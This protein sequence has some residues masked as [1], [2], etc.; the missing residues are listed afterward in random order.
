MPRSSEPPIPSISKGIRFPLE[1][2]KSIRAFA[3]TTHRSYT[4]AVI[5]LCEV[6]LSRLAA[7]TTQLSGTATEAHEQ[8]I[9]APRPTGRAPRPIREQK[10]VAK[11]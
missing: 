8:R 1:L 5:E 6:A 7:E 2:E 3:R 10:R 9:D 4:G 11:K